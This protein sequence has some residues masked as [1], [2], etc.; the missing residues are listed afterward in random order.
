MSKKDVA[1]GWVPSLVAVSP[2][3]R[4]GR[5][6]VFFLLEV[7]LLSLFLSRLLLSVW[8]LGPF[9]RACGSLRSVWFSGRGGLCVYGGWCESSALS[10]R[11]SW[12]LVRFF[13]WSEARG[14]RATSRF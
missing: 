4:V 5:F 6:P 2:L 10:V 12:S 11:C 13:F 14:L 3:L 9:G 7:V 1:R 8:V